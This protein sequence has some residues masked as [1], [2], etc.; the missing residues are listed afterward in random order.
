ML[1]ILFRHRPTLINQSISMLAGRRSIFG[2]H[3]PRFSTMGLTAVTNRGSLPLIRYKVKD[4]AL[5]QP[6]RLAVTAQ[7]TATAYLISDTARFWSP[8]RTQPQTLLL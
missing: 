6:S 3:T 2:C 4:R 1:F 5:G 7:V 8:L